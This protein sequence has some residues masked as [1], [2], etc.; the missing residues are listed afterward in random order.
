MERED[1][2]GSNDVDGGI[3]WKKKRNEGTSRIHP[4]MELV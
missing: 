1:R 4:L 2:G 3:D